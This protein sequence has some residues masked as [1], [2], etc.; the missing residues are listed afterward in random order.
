M[1]Y[2]KTNINKYYVHDAR[3]VSQ[4][5][6]DR[7][8][9]NVTITSPPYWNIKDYGC[10]KQIGFGQS[11]Q[12]YLDDIQAVFS[13]IYKRT[14]KNGSLW[15]VSD[16]FKYEGELRLLPFDIS[17]RLKSCGWILQDIIIWQKDRTLPWSHQGKLRNI[18]EYIA[19]YS[20]SSK[21]KYH[22][23]AI[24]DIADIKNYW[25]NYPE[26]Y[27][28]EGKAPSRSWHFAIPKQGSWGKNNYVRHACPL[29]PGLIERILKLT[30][31]KGD[32]V[33]DPFAG[34]GSVLATAKALNRNYIGIDLN[35]NYKDMFLKSVLPSIKAQFNSRVNIADEN[36]L[37]MKKFRDLIVQLRCLK[38]PKELSRL[39]SKT[40]IPAC[41]GVL[42]IKIARQNELKIQFIFKNKKATPPN[43]CKDLMAIAIK[44]PLSK[45][46]ISATIE[47]TEVNKIDR[48]IGH[49]K[50]KTF[51]LYKGSI[52][53]RW[54]MT[55]SKA[56]L[57]GKLQDLSNDELRSD[58]FPP[59]ISNIKLKIDTRNPSKSL[60]I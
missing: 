42:V 60:E 20:K 13:Q 59:I 50:S 58:R 31:D 40:G 32:L 10:D 12:S 2:L 17:E 43:F 23:S 22:A 56:D 36:A 8:L 34:S 1:R 21:F 4:L 28:P 9:I 7:E 24:K 38:F 44:S 27:S 45:Y 25:I 6:P 51:F 29:P 52:F 48:S 3:T 18:F 33:F 19:F 54:H 26:R 37:T 57:K 49:M 30:S 35:K 5:L 55:I 16:T 39:Y 15:L 46:G 47:T 14:K 53:Y 41:L 11:Y